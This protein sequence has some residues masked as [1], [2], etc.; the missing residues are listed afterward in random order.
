MII[1]FDNLAIEGVNLSVELVT[2][3]WISGPGHY[4]IPFLH[5]IN[6]HI[7]SVVRQR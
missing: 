5:S 7:N 2:L 4:Y 1:P 3:E 6:D